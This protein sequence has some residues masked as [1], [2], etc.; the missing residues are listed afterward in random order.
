MR[1]V[2]SNRFYRNLLHLIPPLCV[3]ILLL[4]TYQLY[5]FAYFGPDAFNNFFWVQRENFT[6]MIGHVANPLSSYFRPVGMMYYWLFLRLFD[7]NPS[8]YRCLM[9]SI[10]AGN[11]GLVYFI[12][13]RIGGSRAGAA[14]G[15]MLFASQA[16]FAE[17]YWNFGA[18]FELIA[19]F[20]AFVG[21][22]LWTTETRTWLHAV[23]S[24]LVLLFAV[25]AKEMAITMPVIWFAYDLLVRNKIKWQLLAQSALPLMVAV[26]YGLTK[27]FQMRETSST[28]PYYMSMSWSALSNG[29]GTYF[30]ML[31]QTQFPWQL[32]LLGAFVMMLVAVL[33]RSL[34]AVFFELYVFITFVPVIFL[35]NHRVALFW[36]LPF[37]GL[38]GLAATMTNGVVSF[39][40]TR[41]SS[42]LA[43]TASVIIFAMLCW[44][45]FLFHEKATRPE[46]RWVEDFT[47]EC[48]N[49]VSVLRGLPP[50]RHGEIIFFDSLPPHFEASVLLSATQVALRRTDVDV[51]VV[52]E[53]PPEAAYRIRVEGSRIVNAQ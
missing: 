2:E 27:A 28:D 43:D 16:V 21:I 35:M 42:A 12:L 52:S 39:I 46:R 47:R 31:L 37:L 15:G 13:K 26:L 23:L 3:G 51:R 41:H 40:S 8:A 18:V 33:L 50:P 19:A 53:F 24:S 5:D 10:H 44:G 14:I 29:F 7:L 17:I 34:A 49:F 48:R 30:D 20:F 25:K 32:W 38:C 22:L 36:Y 11:T 1:Q 45:T 9:W 4:K 6:S